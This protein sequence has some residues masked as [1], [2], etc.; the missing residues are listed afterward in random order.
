MI[1]WF[2]G[3]KPKFIYPAYIGHGANHRPLGACRRARMNAPSGPGFAP[4]EPMTVYDRSRHESD[5]FHTLSSATTIESATASD[6]RQP[7]PQDDARDH[8][9]EVA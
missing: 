1:L 8:R 2:L 6:G 4:S 3:T 5:D 7:G 9:G